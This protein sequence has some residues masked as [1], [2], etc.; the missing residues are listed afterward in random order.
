MQ[1]YYNQ[2]GGIL[3]GTLNTFGFNEDIDYWGVSYRQG[4]NW[5]NENG[6]KTDFECSCGT[7]V[8]ELTAKL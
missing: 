6:T 4:M 8:V 3:K 7:L 2:Y 5:L 1:S